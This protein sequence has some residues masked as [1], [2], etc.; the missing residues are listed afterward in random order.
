MNANVAVTFRDRERDSQDLAFLRETFRESKSASDSGERPC[1]ALVVSPDGVILSRAWNVVNSTGIFSAHAETLALNRAAAEQRAS[2]EAA[3]PAI[4]SPMVL[5][6]ATLYASAEPCAMCSGA[7]FF[8]GITRVIFGV[9]S[10]KLYELSG[11]AGQQL[12]LK[13]GA[14]LGSGDRNLE[15]VG[16]L[17]E[18]EALAAAGL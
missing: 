12:W 13:T 4:E 5:T 11:K 7:A 9:R 14:V 3:D 10:A 17:L 16:P 15:V 6:G 1:A 18:D 8:A 2:R